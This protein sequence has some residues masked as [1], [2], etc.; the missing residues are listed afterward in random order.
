M[1][2]AVSL[3][4]GSLPGFTPDPTATPAPVE[5]GDMLIFNKITPTF[6]ANL[7]PGEKIAGAQMEYIGRSEDGGYEVSI[8]GAKSVKREGDSFIWSGIIAPGV[9]GIFDLRISTDILGN[10]PVVGG[11]KITVLNPDP[12]PL[13]AIPQDPDGL[14]FTNILLLDS[15]I[16][17]GSQI[18]GTTLTYNGETEQGGVTVAEIGNST[19]YPYYR[20]GDSLVWKGKIR[21][22]VFVQY[23]LRIIDF[24][25]E[26]IILGGTADL[27]IEN[28][29]FIITE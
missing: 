29:P 14:N 1:F 13:E 17:V 5:M 9:H 2:T 3:A 27:Y 15:N 21:S 24:N 28:S 23:N 16:L 8:N 4:C 26:S 22:N 20:V 6:T 19:E 11:A 12:F 7:S 25:A 18:L 10:L